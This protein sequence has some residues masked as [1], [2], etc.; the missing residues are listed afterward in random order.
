MAVLISVSEYDRLTA[1]RTDFLG[2]LVDF[3]ARNDLAVLDL[4]DVFDDTR[5]R[6]PGREVDWG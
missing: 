6:S 3:R 4:G 5:D 2:A 1:G